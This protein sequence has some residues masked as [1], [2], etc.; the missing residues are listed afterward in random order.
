MGVGSEADI[1]RLQPLADALSAELICTRDVV[2]A[3]WM[4]RQRQVG[5]T[6]RSVAPALYIG[7]GV[8]GDFNHTVGIQRAGTVVVVNSNRRAQ[9]FRACDLGVI[10]DWNEFVPA[11][12]A[13]L[14]GG[15]A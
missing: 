14:T 15:S 11:L 2:E 5:L 10:A 1:S 8:R 3:G 13:E 6:G 12:V 7:V 9:F 4:P